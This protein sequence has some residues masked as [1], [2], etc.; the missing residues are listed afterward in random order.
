M[1]GSTKEQGEGVGRDGLKRGVMKMEGGKKEI[2]AKHI[3]WG[4]L[5]GL[6]GKTLNLRDVT[7]E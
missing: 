4:K 1:V 7:K 3:H 2:K 6:R 5:F